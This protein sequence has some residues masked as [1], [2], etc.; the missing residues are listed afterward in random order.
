MTLTSIHNRPQAWD[1]TFTLPDGRVLGYAE[2]GDPKG[3]PVFAFHGTPGSRLMQVVSDE[4]ARALGVRVIAPDRPGFGLSDYQP[5]RRLVDWPDDI[6]A[7]A[8]GLGLERFALSGISGG[9]PYAAV[10]AWKLAGRL[11]AAAIVSGVGPVRGPDA[12]PALGRKTRILLGGWAKMPPLARFMAAIARTGWRRDPEAIF[13]RI[14]AFAAKVDKPILTRPEVKG[15]LVPG[16][17]EGFRRTGRGIA[18]ELVIFGQ[19]WGFPLEEART[20]VH[21]WHGEAD[22]L[23]PPAMGRRVASRLPNVDAHFIPGAGHYW[24]FDNV[25]MLLRTLRDANV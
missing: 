17:R 10:C 24:V 5:G 7:L 1:Q 13:A 12:T 23:V 14:V 4:P 18:R 19:P 3:V 21:L 2:F 16:L 22:W 20:R 9:G 6:R 8:D 15:A 25:P 11:T